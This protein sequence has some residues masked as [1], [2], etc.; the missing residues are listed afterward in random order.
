VADVPNELTL[1]QRQ[2]NKTKKGLYYIGGQSQQ[3]FF[4]YYEYLLPLTHYM[5]RP[6]NIFL[7]S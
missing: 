1:T 7:Q 2:E 4:Y 6:V 5:F 3:S